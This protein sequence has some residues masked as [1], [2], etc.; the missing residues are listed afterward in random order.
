MDEEELY[1]EG[2]EIRKDLIDMYNNDLRSYD[3]WFTYYLN[4][5]DMPYGVAKAK[6]DD[7]IEW[8]IESLE[9][10]YGLILQQLK[11]EELEELHGEEEE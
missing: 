9:K 7:P 4:N 10:K 2:L 5:G 11:V 8:V 6:T 1:A 3:K